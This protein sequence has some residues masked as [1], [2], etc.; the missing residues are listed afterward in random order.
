MGNFSEKVN[1]FIVEK[2][3]DMDFLAKNISGESHK[4]SNLVDLLLVLA[5]LC[6]VEYNTFFTEIS[7]LGYAI[8]ILSSARSVIKELKLATYKEQKNIKSKK[9]IT[10]FG[11][12][13]TYLILTIFFFVFLFVEINDISHS[14]AIPVLF[15]FYY[16]VFF[17]VEALNVFTSLF[18][19][20][21]IRN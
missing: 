20:E 18:D 1:S 16:F 5:Y 11:L 14:K 8:I 2:L 12:F 9:N 21:I 13:M 4:I 10:H 19:V 15:A 17:I 6:V 7:S 3:Y